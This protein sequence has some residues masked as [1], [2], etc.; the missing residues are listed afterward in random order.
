M[1]DL[2]IHKSTYNMLDRDGC[3]CLAGTCEKRSL[4]RDKKYRAN[5]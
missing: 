3:L 2:G 4:V 5:I 1:V